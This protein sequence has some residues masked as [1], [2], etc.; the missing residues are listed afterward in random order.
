MLK[1]KDEKDSF[2]YLA[3]SLNWCS[4]EIY[5]GMSPPL[6]SRLLPRCL[7]PAIAII[8]GSAS[9]FRALLK[10]YVPRLLG[11]SARYGTGGM[12]GHP[13]NQSSTGDFAL[14]PYG[15]QLSRDRAGGEP[16]SQ[17]DM[18]SAR[19]GS[20][21][22]ILEGGKKGIMMSKEITVKVTDAEASSQSQVAPFSQV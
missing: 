20:Q 13:Y 21:R 10:K 7:R 12:N 3:D 8:C 19:P 11:S 5:A 22:G 4:I 18:F 6:P 17:A 16:D 15:N 14:K 2:Y 9:T 1:L